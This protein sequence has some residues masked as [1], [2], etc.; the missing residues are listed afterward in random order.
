MSAEQ[1]STID[2]DARLRMGD[3]H[4]IAASLDGGGGA[5]RMAGGRQPQAGRLSARPRPPAAGSIARGALRAT[6][7]EPEL[8]A[9]DRG[10]ARH[11]P[12]RPP[13]GPAI[14]RRHGGGARTGSLGW[15]AW[16]RSGTIATMIGEIRRLSLEDGSLAMVNSDSNVRVACW[17]RQPRHRIAAEGEAWFEVRK[18]KARPSP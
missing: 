7:D 16:P 14:G 17:P 9:R 6:A 12:A 5:C 8:G 13:P 15:R 1:S 4:G 3:P 2:D 18:N 10:K 11:P